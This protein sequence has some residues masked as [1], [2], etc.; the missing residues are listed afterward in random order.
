MSER[1]REREREKER[2]RERERERYPS[3]A[4]A[5]RAAGEREEVKD[6]KGYGIGAPTVRSKN[7][8]FS[9]RRAKLIYTLLYQKSQ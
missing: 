5:H 4:W 2:E 1:E 6:G 8:K 7:E 9:E 3:E